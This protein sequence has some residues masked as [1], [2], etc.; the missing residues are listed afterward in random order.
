MLCIYWTSDEKNF[1]E[2]EEVNENNTNYVI[3]KFPKANQ[4]LTS[5]GYRSRDGKFLFWKLI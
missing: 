1:W 4:T 2:L 3:N 5:T